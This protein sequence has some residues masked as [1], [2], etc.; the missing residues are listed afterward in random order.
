MKVFALATVL[1][2]ALGCPSLSVAQTTPADADAASP[3]TLTGNFSLVSDYRFRGISQTA[4]RPA[5]QG[6]IDYSHASG[7]YLGNWNSSISGRSFNEAAGI[8]M[9]FYGGWKPALGAFTFDLGG[10]YYYYPEA[11]V[12]GDEKYDTFEAYAGVS[13]GAL[14]FKAWY[15]VTDW[16]GIREDTGFKDSDGSV[17]YELNATHPLI[18]KLNLIAHVGYQDVRRNGDFDY[19]DYKFGLTYDY[20]GWLLGA[21]LVGTDA[22]DDVYFVGS[23]TQTGDPTV[24]LS[25]GRTF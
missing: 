8:E 2:A 19:F 23:G 11:R 20:R 25:I 13:Y 14:S 17:Y 5:I 1:A 15:A 21:A 4:R 22:D 18:D 16:F 10:L 12:T 7:F 24:V 3:H 6:G 9:D